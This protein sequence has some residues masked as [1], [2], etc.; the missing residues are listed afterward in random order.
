[1]SLFGA[2]GQQ[3]APMSGGASYSGGNVIAL[4]GGLFLDVATGR[5][6]TNPDDFN[7]DDRQVYDA[8]PSAPSGEA[9][10]GNQDGFTGAQIQQSANDYGRDASTPLG[11]V[12]DAATGVGNFVR[13][14]LGPIANAMGGTIPVISGGV[15][16]GAGAPVGPY[17]GNER[18]ASPGAIVGDNKI[19]TAAQSYDGP[20]A[21]FLPSG[22]QYPQP[23]DPYGPSP[24]PYGMTPEQKTDYQPP[25]RGPLDGKGA[26]ASSVNPG[27][28]G[29]SS[30][31][32]QERDRS[33]ADAKAAANPGTSWQDWM[34]LAGGVAAGL[35]SY[36]GSKALADAETEKSRIEAEA[37]AAAGS[38]ADEIYKQQRADLAPW[39]KDGTEALGRVGT[40]EQDNPLSAFN[41]DQNNPRYAFRFNE[42]LKAL[43]N[44][45]GARGGLFSGGGMKAMV[46]YGQNM[47]AQD[48]DKEY[49]RF[50]GERNDRLRGLQS[51]ANIGQTATQQVGNATQNYGDA[52]TNALAAGAA[53]RG[54]GI[55]GAAAANASMYGGLSNSLTNV[56]GNMYGTYQ[57]NKLF[58][59]LAQMTGG[60]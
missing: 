39:L 17:W 3:Q 22:S 15:G 26:L 53:A 30:A 4:P 59:R 33:D 31:A 34:P 9:R 5:M 25:Y 21:P 51:R 19:A 60:K 46:D 35:G 55:T 38:K 27:G 14:V 29:R 43:Q 11:A 36:L 28:W 32:T 13:P 47:A 45:M 49:N 44:S 24:L 42:G 52:S 1:M 6:S 41:Y 23:A 16:F 56:L 12:A 54:E 57:N 40:F 7:V 2:L 50:Y 48:Y 18:P 37:A 20:S 8:N 10:S 58:D